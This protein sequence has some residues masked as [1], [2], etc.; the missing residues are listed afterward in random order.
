L[1]CLHLI[2]F[3]APNIWAVLNKLP[4]AERAGYRSANHGTCLTGTRIAELQ[5]IEEWE[6]DYTTKLVYWLRGVPGSGKT[7]IAQTF[8]ERSSAGGRLGASFFCSRDFEDRRNIYLIFPTLAYYLA[9]HSPEFRA[10]LIPIINENPDIGRESLAFQFDN[11]LVR[12]LQAAGIRAT[13]VIDALDECEDNQ[14]VSA[15]LS[16]LGRCINLIPYIKFFITGRPELPIRTGFRLPSLR[17]HTEV[18]LLHEVDRAFVDQDIEL[19]LRTRLLEIVAER[20]HWDLTVPWPED[21]EV[22]FTIEKC[23]G[24]FIVASVIVKFVSSRHHE[25]RERLKIITSRPVSTVHEGRLG[26]DGIYYKVLL[27]SFEDVDMDEAK[28]FVHLRL[29]VGSIVV[30]FNPLSCASL[31]AVLGIKESRVWTPL[32]TL[33]SIFIVPD[34]ELEPIRICHKSLADYLTDG[35]RCTD[36]RFY[37]KPSVPHLELGLRCLRLMN[38]SLKKNICALPRYAM[39]ADIED[40]YKRREKYIG[41]GLE[42]GCRSW[43]K[44]LGLASR[45]DD[46]DNVGDVVECLKDFFE[47]HLL[48]WLE[49]LSIVGDLRSAVYSLHD[50]IAW[51]VDVSASSDYFKLLLIEHN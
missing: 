13:I 36:T 39:N 12:P 51:F 42:Y 14:P 23:S 28:F 34:S 17:P 25:P 10:A 40:L 41:G 22:V 30:V 20:S 38:A 19:Y 29:V 47:R 1:C 8:A 37:I 7:T 24:L 16:L 18:F 50:V 9:I 6:T 5:R 43:A 46:S 27:Q 3:E 35:T 45:D 48:A 49:V 21:K 11:L 15:I 31:A 2:V 26:I 44:H 33:H 32:R 4:H